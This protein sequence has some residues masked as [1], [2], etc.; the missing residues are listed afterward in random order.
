[1][2]VLLSSF[3]G[4]DNYRD[5]GEKKWENLFNTFCVELINANSFNGGV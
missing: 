2:T 3:K 1:V 5:R 4:S